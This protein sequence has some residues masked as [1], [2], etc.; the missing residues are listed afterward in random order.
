[1]YSCKVI[2]HSFEKNLIS[3]YRVWKHSHKCSRFV[4]IIERN[5]WQLEVNNTCDIRGETR[6][7]KFNIQRKLHKTRELRI[8]ILT[9]DNLPRNTMLIES[10]NSTAERSTEPFLVFN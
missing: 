6:E 3:S 5:A 10:S 2:K 9:Y 4:S 8:I 1:M 7:V